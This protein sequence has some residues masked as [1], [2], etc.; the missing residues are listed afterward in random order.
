MNLTISENANPN[1][2]AKICKIK[3]LNP[4]EGADRLLKTVINGYDIVVSNDMA[5]GDMVVYFPVESVICERLLGLNNLYELSCYELNA[6]KDE[7][8]K[9]FTEKGDKEA[10][11]LCGFF[12]KKG[13]VR[14]IR[15]R[16]CPSQGFVLPADSLEL[17]SEEYKGTDWEEYNN[18]AF[19]CIDGEKICWKYVI[20]IKEAT[21][22]GDKSK[23]L[24]KK[25]R[26]FDRL[27]PDQFVFHYDTKK[28][29]D[30]IGNF[31]PDDNVTI[32][33]KVH[34]TSAIIAKVLCNKKLNFFEKIKKFFGIKVN[35][36]EY[37][38][39]YSSRKTI[40]NRYIN[41]NVNSFYS[42][43]VWGKAD[44]LVYPYLDE[45]MT[46]YG[47]IVGYQDGTGR[48]IQKYHD[49]GCEVGEWKFMPYRITMTDDYGNKTEWNVQDVIE[50]TNGLITKL[51]EDR[52]KNIMPMTLLYHGRFGDLYSDIKEDE[53]WSQNVLA[54]LK[55]D[56]N[57]L[58]EE[59]E[60]MCKLGWDEYNRL[61]VSL[62]K[63][64]EDN[65]KTGNFKKLVKELTKK[66]ENAY[67][68]LA[69]RE[70]IV[71]RIDNDK[72]PEAWKLKT[73]AHYRLETKLLDE[74]VEDIE[75]M[76]SI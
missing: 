45:G 48:M 76:E 60:P 35:T 49:Y 65:E 20:P 28:I 47:E 56:K 34:G 59:K 24:N 19:D 75:E 15:L 21:P 51:P 62:E 68:I 22:R 25:L 42:V 71:F 37:G 63:A 36:L 57:F 50:W 30:V 11:K 18:M 66:V 70:G 40:K 73:D 61:S 14:C 55:L 44:E 32:T 31:N 46:V 16:G 27:V 53:D 52:K 69:P 43:D 9:T 38:N 6:N 67:A 74:G 54:R 72:M 23:K 4:I 26:R 7:V 17:L 64:K 41:P 3:E 58:M 39:V 5:I 33:V 29:N 1:Y 12:T 10:R 13:R 2:L 8:E